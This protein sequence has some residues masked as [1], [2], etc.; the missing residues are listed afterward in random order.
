MFL[1]NMWSPTREIDGE[2]KKANTDTAFS[3]MEEEDLILMASFIP[4]S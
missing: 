3:F 1:M 2:A 4:T